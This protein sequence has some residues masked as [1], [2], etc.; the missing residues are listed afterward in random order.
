MLHSIAVL[1]DSSEF[2]QLLQAMLNYIGITDIAAWVSSEQALPALL[3][4]P[5]DLLLLDVMMAGIG[6]LDVWARLR[7]APATQRL[8]IIFC[9]AAIN[10]LVED[11]LRLAQDPYSQMLPKPFTLD[12]LKHAI[13]ALI[14]HWNA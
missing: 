7:S 6:G 8:P 11:E 13:T 1:D 2:Q 10:R 12:E 4:N 14:P 9:T 3:E 5:P